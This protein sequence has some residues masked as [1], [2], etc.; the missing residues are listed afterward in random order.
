MKRVFIFSLCFIFSCLSL[1][2]PNEAITIELTDPVYPEEPKKQHSLTRHF[3]DLGFPTGYSMYLTNKVCLDDVCKLVEVTLYWDA[4]GYYQRLTYPEGQ[5]LTKVEHEPFTEAD[6][7]KLDTILKD[8]KSILRDHELGF[9]ATDTDDEPTSY[10]ADSIDGTTKATPG[11]VKEAVVKDA[12]WTTWV[13]WKYANTEIVSILQSTTESE[14]SPAYLEHLL[15]SKDWRKIKFALDYLLKQMPVPATYLDRVAQLLPSADI[16]HVE[17]AIAYLQQASPDKTSGYRKLISTLP[18]LEEYSASL[19]I[20]LLE[21]DDQLDE[22]ILE[23]LTSH[24]DQ[25]D[26]YPI[27]LALR[28]IESRDAFSDTVESNVMKLLQSKD[29]FIARRAY[30][31]LSKQTLSDSAKLKLQ[32]FREKHSDRL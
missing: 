14:C 24:L 29:F 21:A 30:D 32:A 23:E 17:L 18:N 7:Q 27:H 12:A 3:D 10:N 8:R 15:A 11:A 22:T 26:Y 13:L 9:L 4:M 19:I 28:L 20:E 6:Y 25:Q 31:Y 5:P 1:A 16:D 2:R